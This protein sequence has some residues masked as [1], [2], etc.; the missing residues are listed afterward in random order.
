MRRSKTTWMI[1]YFKEM[2]DYNLYDPSSKYQIV[3]AQLCFMKVIQKKLDLAR[4]HWNSHMI[5]GS[6]HT[7]IAG[8]PDQMY[9]LPE[10]NCYFDQLCLCDQLDI[11]ELNSCLDM[12][13]EDREREIL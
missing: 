4:M 8:R 9:Y 5:R 12:G 3:C 2:I 7:E 1:N 11:N 13:D 10:N 6:K